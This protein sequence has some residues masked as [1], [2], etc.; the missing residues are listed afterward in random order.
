M[1]DEVTP[2]WQGYVQYSLTG[3]K[4]PPAGTYTVS[5]QAYADGLNGMARCYVLPPEGN[6]I[7]SGAVVI[8][9]G[10]TVEVSHTAVIPDACRELIIRICPGNTLEAS[11]MMSDI[12]IE[13]TKTYALAS[14]GGFQASSPRRPRHT[15]LEAGDRR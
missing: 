4:V 10:Q 13:P 15:E 12:S 14:G 1:L 2:N 9:A 3:S 6:Y 5:L 7:N 8:P 11:A